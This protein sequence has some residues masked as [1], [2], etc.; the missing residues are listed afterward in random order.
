MKLSEDCRCE[1]SEEPV[2]VILFGVA[3]PHA[4]FSMRVHLRLLIGN[5]NS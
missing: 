5:V 4:I 2:H 1:D 3:A